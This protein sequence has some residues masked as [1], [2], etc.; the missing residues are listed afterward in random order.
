MYD[1]QITIFNRSID[2]LKC[3]KKLLLLNPRMF[4][5]YNKCT[6]FIETMMFNFCL[7]MTF[8]KL[9]LT[10]DKIVMKR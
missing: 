5:F 2:P 10:I 6:L 7:V 9:N 1:K 4:L 8:N 3:T